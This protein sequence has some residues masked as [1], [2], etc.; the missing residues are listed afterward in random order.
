MNS[1]AGHVPTAF[2]IR[3][4]QPVISEPPSQKTPHISSVLSVY[5][6][7]RS[8]I[9]WPQRNCVTRHTSSLRHTSTSLL[10]TRTTL[11]QPP[12]SKFEEFIRYRSKFWYHPSVL[13]LVHISQYLTKKTNIPLHNRIKVRSLYFL[14]CDIYPGKHWWKM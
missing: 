8:S 3:L 10:T 13:S 1:R 6:C 14:Y 4:I 5:M 9:L 12:H 2:C 7:Y 11:F